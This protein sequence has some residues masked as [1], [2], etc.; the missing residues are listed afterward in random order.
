MTDTLEKNGILSRDTTGSTFAEGVKV[1]AGSRVHYSTIDKAVLVHEATVEHS[2]VQA[3]ATISAGACVKNNSSIG[4]GCIINEQSLVDK[5]GLGQHT[6]VLGKAQVI[7]S[8]VQSDCVIGSHS[9]LEG[10]LLGPHSTVSNNAALTRCAIGENS[11]INGS[12]ITDCDIG[13]NCRI[14]PRVT[15][16]AD[17][18]NIPANATLSNGVNV[19]LEPTVVRLGDNYLT[20]TDQHVTLGG[21]KK[22]SPSITHAH[23]ELA[24]LREAKKP[25]LFSRDKSPENKLLRELKNHMSEVEEAI[26]LQNFKLDEAQR[27]RDAAEVQAFRKGQQQERLSANAKSPKNVIEQ[28]R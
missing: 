28:E 6:Q 16:H 1:S 14:E 15:L 7:D 12:K 8:I 26:G 27:S 22:D 3:L 10:C 18:K 19:S 25:G 23:T 17:V 5:S 24:T 20:V 11:H 21:N 4:M 13:R 2:K 9:R